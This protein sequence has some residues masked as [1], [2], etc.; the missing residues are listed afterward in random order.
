MGARALVVGGN[1]FIGSTLVKRLL[2]DGYVVRV[3][4]RGVPRVDFDW[5]GVDYVQGDLSGRELDDVVGGSEVV[6]H[7][8][9]STVPST[10]NNDPHGDVTSNLLGAL[11]LMHSMRRVGSSRIVFLSSG[12]TVY[13]NP[14]VSPVREDAPLCPIS[15]YGVVK[16]AIEKYLGM[17]EALGDLSPLVI[18]PSNPYGPGQS[19]AGQQGAIAVFLGKALRGEPVEIWGD[20]SVVRDYIYIDDLV[21]MIMKAASGGVTGTFN[22]GSGRG[23]SL[24]EVCDAIRRVSGVPLQILYR[25]SRGFDVRRVVLDI[26]AAREAFGWAPATGLDYGLE[27]TWHYLTQYYCGHDNNE[28]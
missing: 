27:L 17:Y 20:G 13:G 4:D 15:S 1:G 7:L 3:L 10:S 22:A 28:R 25:E 24:R 9:S 2:A 12:G 18:R 21:D 14:P 11:S 6:F 23:Y 8:A 16:V 19:I 5:R 26:T